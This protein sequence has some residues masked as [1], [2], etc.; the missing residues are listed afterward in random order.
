M[1]EARRAHAAAH[2][3]DLGFLIT[4]GHDGG[5][6]SS[7][8]ITKDV[9]IFEDLILSPTAFIST[10]LWLWTARMETSSWQ[11]DGAVPHRTKRGPSFIKAATGFR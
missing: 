10:V 8:E 4:G 2:H 6:K 11:E 3:K 5:Y 1:K 7:T 9:V